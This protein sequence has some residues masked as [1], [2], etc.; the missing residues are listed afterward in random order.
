[1]NKKWWV[2]IA[3]VVIG[4]LSFAGWQYIGSQ[5]QARVEA[6]E[7]METAIVER[8][9]LRVTLDATG[10]LA[11][12]AEVSLAFASS[13]QVAEVFVE[14]GQQVEAGQ[15]L[16]QLDTDDLA[17]QVTQA[18]ISLREAELELETLL[19]PADQSDIEQAQDA[20][21]QAAASIQLT[22]I[23]QRTAQD[24]VLVNESLEDAQEA[25]DDAL[26]DYEYWLEEYNENDADHWFVE[27]A[28]EKLEDKELDLKRVQEQVDESLQSAGNDLATA[29]DV[30]RQAQNNLQDLLDGAGDSD[31]EAAQL[32]IDQA[33]ASLE[34]VQLQLADATLIAPLAGTVTALDIQPGEMA[35]AGQAAVVVI[36]DLSVLEVEINL[37]ETDVA[38]VAVGQETLVS[39]DAFPE[40][41]L[42]GEVTYIAPVA[43]TQSGVVLYAVT[44]RIAPTEF[45]IR[46]GMTADVEIVS[47]SQAGALIVPLRA[48]SSE[49]ERSYITRLAGGRPE[50]VEVELGLTTET[51]IEITT[52][53]SEGDV[54]VVAGGAS[55][56]T[57]RPSGPMGMFGG[58][59]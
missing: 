40:A 51:E 23:S 45:P 55:E 11:P 32:Q 3:V 8:D 59:E 37:D 24:S 48:I 12:Q 27:N 21:D 53:L 39:V 14:E 2:V 54:V 46:A 31:I 58:R 49:G 22:H 47:A 50:R 30:Y 35:S 13:G 20:V 15:A 25:Y 5:Q 28:L 44:V 26:E 38:Q 7:A 43:E 41:E 16:A 1:M 17:L 10:S 6:R 57:Q 42:S 56:D 52:G 36:S 19:E 33:R 18:E 34:Q 29:A 4:G 9:T